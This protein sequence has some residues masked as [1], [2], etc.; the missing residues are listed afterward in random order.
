MYTSRRDFSFFMAVMAVKGTLTILS[1]CLTYSYR[2]CFIA[3]QTT[4]KWK[5]ARPFFG[6]QL[7]SWQSI[8][9]KLAHCGECLYSYIPLP[10]VALY[11]M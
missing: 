3:M 9:Y 10:H 11:H 8:A 6:A 7:I 2:A 4:D 1:H 5:L